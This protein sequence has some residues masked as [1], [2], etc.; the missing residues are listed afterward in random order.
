M[1]KQLL[2]TL[3]IIGHISL[4]YSASYIGVK[5]G[6]MSTEQE[7]VDNQGHLAGKSLTGDVFGIEFG[8]FLTNSLALEIGYEEIQYEEFSASSS[9]A[10]VF[11]LRSNGNN[12]NINLGFRWFLADWLNLHLGGVRTEYDPNLKVNN[13]ITEFENETVRDTTQYY[14][15]GFGFTFGR[16]QLFYDHTIHQNKDG[17]DAQLNKFGL[18]LFF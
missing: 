5:M 10:P 6:N 3:F 8:H 1:I 14:G 2:F 13:G 7:L 15:V 17:E 11:E 16:L 18:R 4:A 12:K 9:S